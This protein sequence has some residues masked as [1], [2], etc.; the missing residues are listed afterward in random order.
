MEK[1]EE[2][3]LILDEFFIQFGGQ[4]R[5]CLEFIF[6][7]SYLSE[8][9]TNLMA[10]K[11]GEIISKKWFF[12]Q[13][14]MPNQ[15]YIPVDGEPCFSPERGHI[16]GLQRTLNREDLKQALEMILTVAQEMGIEVRKRN[17]INMAEHINYGHKLEYNYQTIL[18][19]K[20][21]EQNKSPKR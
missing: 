16:S 1:N 12:K 14:Y 20:A 19:P 4:P 15:T 7:N 11:Y 2:N 21:N 8:E 18:K 13:E 17:C 6:N 9:F 5:Y 10:E 3:I